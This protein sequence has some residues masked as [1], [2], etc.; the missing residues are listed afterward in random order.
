MGFQ[1]HTPKILGAKSTR[2]TTVPVPLGTSPSEW[3]NG[4]FCYNL[5]FVAVIRLAK[6]RVGT[7]IP[8]N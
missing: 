4:Q 3:I 5:V 8:A 7:V 2:G 6:A 1:I